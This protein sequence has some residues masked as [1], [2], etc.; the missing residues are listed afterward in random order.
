MR[1]SLTPFI[2]TP[3]K[4]I[5]VKNYKNCWL[6]NLFEFIRFFLNRTCQEFPGV[7]LLRL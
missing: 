3:L 7:D 1:Q 6:W 4:T 5:T 2:N